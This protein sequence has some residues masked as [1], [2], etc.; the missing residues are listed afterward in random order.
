MNLSLE[1]CAAKSGLLQNIHPCAKFLATLCFALCTAS[2]RDPRTLLLFLPVLGII[3]IIARIPLALFLRRIAIALPFALFTGIWGCFFDHTVVITIANFPI[4][5]GFWM[6]I[7]ILL[8]TWLGVGIVLMLV[9]TT[10]IRTIAIAM[11]VM[12][13]PTEIALLFELICRYLGTLIDEVKRIR[14]AYQLRG[15]NANSTLIQHFG[16][17]AGSLLLHSFDRAQRIYHAMICRGYPNMPQHTLPSITFGEIFGTILFCAF[18]IC[19]RFV[20]A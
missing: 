9:G 14:T 17:L 8:R 18:C 15:G 3:H 10:P 4:T 12:H 2:S 13:C 6:L 11:R 7:S 1:Q 20:M 5:G 16:S 19:L